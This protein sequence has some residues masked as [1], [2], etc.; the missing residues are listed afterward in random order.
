MNMY[1]VEVQLRVFYES[2]IR[3]SYCQLRV[4]ATLPRYA[5]GMRAP[6]DVQ[7][8]ISF[9]HSGNWTF[10]FRA[11]GLQATYRRQ[12]LFAYSGNWTPLSGAGGLQATYRRQY[13]LAHSVNWTPLSRAGGLQA[14]ISFAHSG[15]WTPLSRAGRL[16]ATISLAHSGNWTP[17][18]RTGGFQ[19]TYR[20]Q[21][22][23]PI[24]GIEHPFL[25]GW[26]RRLVITPYPEI[27]ETCIF[28]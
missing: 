22:L 6:G 27:N 2:N 8:T 1:G 15:N 12:Y 20:R 19:A 17:L 10:L 7:K 13:S 23:L 9:A 21:Y 16:Q 25:A 14:T 5:S 28:T 3:R 4:S 18:S 24:P 11:G 26:D